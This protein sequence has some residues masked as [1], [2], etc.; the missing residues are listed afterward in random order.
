MVIKVEDAD[1]LFLDTDAA[2]YKIF[3]G[4]IDE[5]IKLNYDPR[6]GS[7]TISLSKMPS[8]RVYQKL[9]TEYTGAG[10]RQ[11]NFKLTNQGGGSGAVVFISKYAPSTS[12]W[13]D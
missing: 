2:E 4:E 10:W 7:L 3:E 6:V 1:L 9:L 5:A 11:V 13:K 12:S 8:G